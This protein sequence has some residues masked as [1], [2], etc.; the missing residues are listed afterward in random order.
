MG[1]TAT[2]QG[3]RDALQPRAYAAVL[4]KTRVHAMGRDP[5]LGSPTRLAQGHTTE[6]G[7]RVRSPNSRGSK[8]RE[9]G[10]NG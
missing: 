10:E 7:L 1:P 4:G 8:W 9:I 2:R 3:A 5:S 6:R